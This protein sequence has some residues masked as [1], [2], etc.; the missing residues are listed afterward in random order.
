[1]SRVARPHSLPTPCD[2]RSVPPMGKV[3]ASAS[4][5]LDGF[6][7]FDDNT[8][9]DLFEWYENG[10]VEV[11][12]E[13]ELPPFHLTP[14]SAEYWKAFVSTLGALVVG[15]ELFAVTDGWH[16]RHP[17]GVPVVVLTHEPPLDWSYPGSEDFHFV[18]DGIAPAIELAHGIAGDRTV[19]VAAGT[20]ARQ[21]LDAGLLDEVGID[22]VP[23]IM[24]SGRRFFGDGPAPTRFGDPTR[25]VAGRRV[26]HLAFPVERD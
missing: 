22:L 19:S 24:G 7:A 16:G 8:I 6:I 5:S 13:G 12:N 9:G 2:R 15:R 21:A 11:E 26:T 1:M 17:L 20:V 10:E 23:I 25:V 18:T 14:Q 4:M 3:I